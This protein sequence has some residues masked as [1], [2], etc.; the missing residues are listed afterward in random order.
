MAEIIANENHVLRH[1]SK[2]PD[3]RCLLV[4]L[5]VACIAFL[6][7]LGSAGMFDPTDS[8][9]IE[10]GREM[11]ET[12]RFIVP[13]MNYEQWLDKPAL[14]FCM[15]AASLGTFGINE[16]AGRLPSALC[17]IVEVV[18]LFILSS[19]L[20]TRRQ[21]FLCSLVLAATP[22]FIVVGRTSLS[23][24]PLSLFLTTCLLSFAVASIKKSNIYLIPAYAALGVAILL[25]GPPLAM[26]LTGLVLVGYLIWS[27]HGAFI[28]DALRLHPIA[29]LAGAFVIAAPYYVWAHVGTNGE[30][31]TN[32]FLRQNLGRAAGT[33]NH[34]RPFWWYFPI[35]FGGTFPW[36]ISLLFAWKYLR[37]V[38]LSKFEH[39]TRRQELL[40]F[41]IAWVVLGFAFFSAVPTKLETYIV[42]IL[43][44]LAIITGCFLDVLVRANLLSRACDSRKAGASTPTPSNFSATQMV[45]T[46]LF[47]AVSI[48]AIASPIAIQKSFDKDGQF[49]PIDVLA[50]V[51]VVLICAC[52]VYELNKRSARFSYA[53]VSSVVVL[54]SVFIPVLFVVYNKAYQQPVDELVSY[55]QS[56]KADLAVAYFPMPSV[57]YRYGHA[58]PVIK[59]RQEMLAYAEGAPDRRWIL[60]NKD[61]LDLLD[62]TERSPRVVARN[63]RWWLF[64]IG[65]NCTIEDTVE[66][67]GPKM[68]PYPELADMLKSH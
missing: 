9:F 22:L 8:F 14:D 19:Q 23:D 50:A 46:A 3:G 47:A 31:T 15:I 29:G 33:V 59:S 6:P 43:P 25:K 65:R 64:A 55:A 60:I 48:A 57:I 66:W 67:H 61:V 63:G 45:A 41:A 40:K 10:S 13:L 42:P 16:F 1:V 37:K 20:L 58:I 62:W 53:L 5:F 2:K 44:A 54:S 17:G 51:T 39:S 49:L 28:R 36:S 7:F 24:E 11:L 18:V 27:R 21:A 34:V 12:H 32:F 68:G 26:V 30:F 52:G 56:H 35:V 4:V 38:A